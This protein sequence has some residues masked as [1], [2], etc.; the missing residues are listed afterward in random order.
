M[1]SRKHPSTFVL[2]ASL[3]LG[4][5]P[6]HAAGEPARAEIIARGNG[7]VH[8]RPDSVRV[9]V[10]IE[11][12]AAT[13]DE[14]RTTVDG[15]MEHVIAALKAARLPDL[16]IETRSIR[17]SPV[18]GPPRDNR[19]PAI[20]GFTGSN[21]VLVTTPKVPDAELAV[22]ASRI[23]DTALGAGANNVGSIDFFLEDPSDAENEALTLAVHHAGE[24]AETMAQAAG[25]TLSGPLTIEE[26]APS[27][28]P[29]SLML[30]APMA[31]TPVE[32][33]DIVVQVSV[34]AKYAFH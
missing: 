31:S 27:R 25:V 32:V 17:F 16:A 34:T 21:H 26:T 6:A 14:V 9:D 20:V 11:A 12:E 5:A 33:G 2:L 10:G 29:R 8:V 19:P 4:A 13:L 23:V 3:A 7:E 24:D 28:G 30:A 1:L 22:R 18:Y 15:S